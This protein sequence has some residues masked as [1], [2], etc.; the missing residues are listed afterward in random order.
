MIMDILFLMIAL[1]SEAVLCFV[2]NLATFSPISIPTKNKCYPTD[3]EFQ[4]LT[5]KFDQWVK[6][7]EKDRRLASF[8]KDT[9]KSSEKQ[10]LEAFVRHQSSIDS[11]SAPFLGI[12]GRSEEEMAVY[13]STK[14]AQVC[15]IFLFMA[16]GGY[17]YEFELGIISN[18]K[19]Y[20]PDSSNSVFFFKQDRFLGWVSN[21]RLPH[22][23]QPLGEFPY[24]SPRPLKD[25]NDFLGNWDVGARERSE[26]LQKYAAAGCTNPHISQ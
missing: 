26:I 5:E 24:H 7:L 16:K 22:E 9:R 8:I 4:R 17:T 19:V 21:S 3:A 2:A 23:F 14:K 1:K 11:T 6:N 12:W 18:N 20:L 10:I 13:P 25:V 15:L